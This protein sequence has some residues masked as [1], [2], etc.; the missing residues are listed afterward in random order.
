LDEAS[1]TR[2]RS[3][4]SGP[5]HHFGLLETEAVLVSRGQIR[6]GNTTDAGVRPALAAHRLRDGAITTRW[7][8]AAQIDDP[9][10]TQN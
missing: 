6:A 8:R 2:L 3:Q 4:G 10:T 9:P 5:K 1:V 7:G